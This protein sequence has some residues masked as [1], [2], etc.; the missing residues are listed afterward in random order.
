MNTRLGIGDA[1]KITHGNL[2]RPLLIAALF[3]CSCPTKG[4]VQETRRRVQTIPTSGIRNHMSTRLLSFDKCASRSKF[5]VPSQ[6]KARPTSAGRI[7]KTQSSSPFYLLSDISQMT[8]YNIKV[9]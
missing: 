8:M 7:C 5:I 4:E 9:V 1:S 2:V 3:Y 6:G